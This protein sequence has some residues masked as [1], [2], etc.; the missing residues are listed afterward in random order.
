MPEGP[1]HAECANS[2]IRWIERQRRER[3]LE[4]T[5]PDES[6]GGH[7]VKRIPASACSA[8]RRCSSCI[9]YAFTTLFLEATVVGIEEEKGGRGI[10][11]GTEGDGA[12]LYVGT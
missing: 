11:R 3:G 10:L 6:M 1:E 5:A 12:F 9:S 8:E 4:E 7:Y 2:E